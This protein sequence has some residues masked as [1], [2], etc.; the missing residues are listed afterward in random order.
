MQG[1]CELKFRSKMCRQS[2]GSARK[3]VRETGSNIGTAFVCSPALG[4]LGVFWSSNRLPK[5]WP[6]T[7]FQIFLQQRSFYS[8]SSEKPEFGFANSEPVQVL[9]NLPDGKA[10]VFL[11]R[12]K[13]IER[14]IV[15][16]VRAFHWGSPCQER[17][18]FL[19]SCWALL[20]SHDVRAPFWPLN[21]IC[22]RFLSIIIFFITKY[23]HFLECQIKRVFFHSLEILYLILHILSVEEQNRD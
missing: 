8:G 21:S 20:S 12:G 9:P 22:L 7:N 5:C 15:N 1:G 16:K 11:K 13:E 14:P 18:I 17:N 6:T 19:S 23:L 2:L 4:P 3:A 10:R